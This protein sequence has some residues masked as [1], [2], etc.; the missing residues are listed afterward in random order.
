[1]TQGRCGGGRE[2]GVGGREYLRMDAQ[3]LPCAEGHSKY[4]R[5]VPQLLVV[6][7]EQPLQ[8]LNCL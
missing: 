5:H 4:L 2:W 3:V 7:Q 1:M 6:G 8:L